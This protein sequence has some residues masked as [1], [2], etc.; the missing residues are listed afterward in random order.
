M[1]A[2]M[3]TQTQAGGH[4]MDKWPDKA[5]VTYCWKMLTVAYMVFP[6]FRID[7]PDDEE[8]GGS[9]NRESPASGLLEIGR[10]GGGITVEC[11][12]VAGGDRGHDDGQRWSQKIGRQVRKLS[13]LLVGDVCPE[14]GRKQPKMLSGKCKSPAAIVASVEV[15]VGL[16]WK[17]LARGSYWNGW[18]HRRKLPEPKNGPKGG[19][20]GDELL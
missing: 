14:N 11:N 18:L 10:E 3:W 2:G 20:G 7:N 1:N 8:R 16:K 5:V 12:N 15:G 6:P 13:G 4:D 19:G 17:I 9:G